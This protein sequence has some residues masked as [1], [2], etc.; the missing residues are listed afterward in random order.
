[1]HTATLTDSHFH[2]ITTGGTIDTTHIDDTDDTL[3]TFQ[4]SSIPE[5]IH[6]WKMAPSVTYTHLTPINS[7]FMK[8][9][10]RETILQAIQVSTHTKIL[11]T[12]GTDTMVETA[13]YLEWKVQ[14]KR[15]ILVWAMI[16]S[17]E[18]HTDAYVNLSFAL[19]IL[20]TSIE[21]GV[22]I[23]MNGQVFSPQNVK[24]N[25]DVIPPRFEKIL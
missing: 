18:N 21:W 20:E 11:I 15:V 2:I 9:D 17:R 14:G 7:L 24:K 10:Y 22:F 4:E 1:M 25:R 23:A 13:K 12:H 16:P 5:M 3:Y 6:Q 19:W 8:D